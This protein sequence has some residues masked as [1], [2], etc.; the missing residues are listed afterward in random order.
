MLKELN[1]LWLKAQ[2]QAAAWRRWYRKLPHNR[3]R[4]PRLRD[5]H[6]WL[7]GYGP[8]E[9][10]PEPELH[11]CFCEKVELPSGRFEVRLSGGRVE[12]A[13]RLARYPRRAPEEVVPLP[14]AAEEV[15]RR[16]AKY[17]CR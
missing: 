13:Y 14:M 8:P 6:G 7:I 1:K 12:A 10:M 16:Y 2:R 5:E 9:P 3:T 15:R 17:C 4:R 11:P